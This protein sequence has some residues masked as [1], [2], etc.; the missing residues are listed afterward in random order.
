MG[1]S[2][3]YFPALGG[4]GRCDVVHTDNV[5]R[6]SCIC[7]KRVPCGCYI[8]HVPTEGTT[9]KG[10]SDD[11]DDGRFTACLGGVPCLL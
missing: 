11:D 7:R 10:E 8:G 4:A 9:S 5:P 2:N 6:V 1:F 3:I